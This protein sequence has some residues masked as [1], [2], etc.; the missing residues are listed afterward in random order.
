MGSINKNIYALD[1]KREVR[2]KST[3]RSPY[4]DDLPLA[5]KYDLLI[6]TIFIYIYIRIYIYQYVV[7]Y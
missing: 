7:V 2:G 3:D 5:V 4:R 1:G 6:Y